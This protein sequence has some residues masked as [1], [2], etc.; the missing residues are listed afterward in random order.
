MLIAL[1]IIVIFMLVVVLTV[2]SYRGR[3]DMYYDD[4]EEVI[5]TTTTTTTTV[6]EPAPEYVIEGK[7]SRQFDNGQPFVID[8][9]DGAKIWV[10]DKD[11]LYED[12]HDRIWELI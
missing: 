7:L 1:S 2:A 10:N 4:E 6:D 3:S 12:A 5:T 9:A 11:D 8:P